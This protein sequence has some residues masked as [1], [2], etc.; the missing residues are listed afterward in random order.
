M[1]VW[2]IIKVSELEGTK[3]L[4]AEYYKPFYLKTYKEIRRCGIPVSRLKEFC[5]RITD[6]SHITPPYIESGI[7]FLMVRDVSE[8]LINFDDNDY[9]SES[10]DR[11]LE[12]CKPSSGDI[13]LT[14][15]GS[16]GIVA[17]VPEK[18]PEFNI[19]VSLAVLKNIQGINKYYLS[20]FLN[21]RFG[22]I[23]AIRQAKGIS[24]PDLH[25][26]EIREFLIPKVD[27]V[28]QR[29]I[30]TL[31]VQVHKKHSQARDLYTQAE[32]MVLNEIG[33]DK[34]DLSQTKWWIASL[35]RAQE[36]HRLDAEHFQP[37]YDKIIAHIKKTSKAKQLSELAPFIKRGLQPEYV[38]GGEVLVFTE[39]HLDRYLLDIDGAE[40]TSLAFWKANSNA[41]LQRA[42]IIMYSIGA[43]IGRANI[44]LEAHKA[45]TS[46]NATIIRVDPSK[47]RPE[48][49]AV[50]LNS[51]IG[52]FQAQKYTASVGQ[53]ALYPADIPKFWIYLPSEKF[54]E[55]VV[56]LV[57]QSYKARQKAKALLEEA[58]AKVEATILGS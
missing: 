26:E 58:K 45:T 1:A 50:Y 47:V 5:A 4:A 52:L 42:D 35:S 13:L 9:I 46:S 8:E 10:F 29:Q 3:R 44:Y 57:Q 25:L 11:R 38:E 23:Q 20:T 12:H 15:V 14:K 49:L 28:F 43:Y 21:S 36:V 41:Q 34:L 33:W 55:K 7:R 56:D 19:F 27:E 2:S 17:V 32:Q 22:R 54:Q 24:Q 39:K 18:A 31:I 53:M 16:V 48:Y 51:N 30:E 40:H 37:K 6:G